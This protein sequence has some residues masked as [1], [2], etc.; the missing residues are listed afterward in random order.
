MAEQIVS[1]SFLAKA[2]EVIQLLCG[3]LVIYFAIGGAVGFI[4]RQ[5]YNQEP[6]CVPF[7]TVFGLLEAT[8][9]NAI[10]NWFWTI[11]VGIPRLFIVFPALWL[12]LLKTSFQNDGNAGYFMESCWWLVVSLPFFIVVFLGLKHWRHRS[13]KLSLYIGITL[14]LEIIALALMA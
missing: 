5:A 1:K 14:M 2:W 3:W 12:S 8:C 10:V 6:S 11:L 7:N 4:F 13:H 9:P